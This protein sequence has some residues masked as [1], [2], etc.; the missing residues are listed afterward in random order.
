MATA[1]TEKVTFSLPAD[2]VQQMRNVVKSG[3]FASQN[4]FV[5][6]ALSR[7]LKRVREE[8]I[9]R[10]YERAAQDPLF[11]QDMEECMHDFR[12]VDAETARMIADDEELD[13]APDSS[14]AAERTA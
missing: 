13:Q 9:A 12:F 1:T 14:R 4:A 10:E 5:R 2:M 8:Q 6:E 3:S 7:E 11:I